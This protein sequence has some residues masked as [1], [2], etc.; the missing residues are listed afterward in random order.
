MANEFFHDEQ[1]EH[2]N[3]QFVIVT[4]DAEAVLMPRK[5]DTG[6]IVSTQFCYGT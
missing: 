6:F 3:L 1:N 4:E 2:P 5:I